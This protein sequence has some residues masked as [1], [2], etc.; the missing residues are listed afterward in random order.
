MSSASS[1]HP[2]ARSRAFS[3]IIGR[4]G[5]G[6]ESLSGAISPACAGLKGL[7]LARFEGMPGFEGIP[8]PE[9]WLLCRNSINPRRKSTASAVPAPARIVHGLRVI[10]F[11]H[12][13]SE[14]RD[15]AVVLIAGRGTVAA[16]GNPIAA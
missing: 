2:R 14:I 16:A 3:A 9:G 6:H 13:G 10:F 15:R 8:G 7:R 12:G 5:K 1:D 11:A 4:S